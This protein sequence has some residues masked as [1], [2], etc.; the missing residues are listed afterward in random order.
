MTNQQLQQPEA[1]KLLNDMA[2]NATLAWNGQG[3]QSG[4]IGQEDGVQWV[5]LHI[6]RLTTMDITAA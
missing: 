6:Q 3:G 2:L 4:G 1:G 5:Y